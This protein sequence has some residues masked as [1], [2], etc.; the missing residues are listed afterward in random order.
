[1]LW[2]LKYLINHLGQET[3]LFRKFNLKQKPKTFWITWPQGRRKEFGYLKV[4]MQG[5]KGKRIRLAWPRK[6]R[7][8]V[9]SRWNPI[10]LIRANNV[11]ANW[12]L[13][14]H[15]KDEETEFP[16]SSRIHLRNKHNITTLF[17]RR[18]FSPVKLCKSIKLG[19]GL[20]AISGSFNKMRP[21]KKH[22]TTQFLH[23]ET[24]QLS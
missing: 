6:P 19:G 2:G 10:I 5:I 17:A 23:V 16:R 22:I 18:W 4:Y 24:V 14:S 21:Q 8:W 1:M 3:I 15:F 12:I 20:S 7:T 13:P 11:Q 9:S